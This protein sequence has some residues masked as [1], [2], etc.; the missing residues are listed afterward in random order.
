M[1]RICLQSGHAPQ[2]GRGFRQ[3]VSLL[4]IVA[5]LLALALVNCGPRALLSAPPAQQIEASPLHPLYAL[6]SQLY[7]GS[8]PATEKDFAALARMG[9]ETLVSVDGAL[10]QVELARRHGLRY[11]H[12]PLPYSG[13]SRE[14]VLQLVA[15]MQQRR[16]PVYIHCHHGRHRGPAAAAIAARC[17]GTFSPA[18]AEEFLDQAGTGKEY[19]GLWRDVRNLEPLSTEERQALSQV[20][21]VETVEQETL[22]ASMARI[23][24]LWS[25]LEALHKQDE[26][27][28]Q[29]FPAADFAAKSV[30]LAEEFQESARLPSD[31]AA[32]RQGLRETAGLARELSA[33]LETSQR[34]ELLRRVGSRCVSCHADHRG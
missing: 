8:R 19:P 33:A 20:P 26:D 13:I 12:I 31:V 28:S 10:P 24:M 21:L 6:S 4:T 22:A 17:Q 14:A 15:V 16:G 1:S 23:E 29:P 30:L 2:G 3:P 9:I 5:G 34:S 7:T 18:Q 25:E 27:S 11:V 32:L